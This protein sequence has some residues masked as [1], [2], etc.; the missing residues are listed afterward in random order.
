MSTTFSANL[1]QQLPWSSGCP[2]TFLIL[3]LHFQIKKIS[4]RKNN[5]IGIWS[6][7]IKTNKGIFREECLSG[8]KV[9]SFI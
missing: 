2:V 3:A 5:N 7:H 6:F 4:Q 1:K 9:Y 8:A